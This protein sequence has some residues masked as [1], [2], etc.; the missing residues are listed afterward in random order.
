MADIY[1]QL[2]QS[3]AMLAGWDRP[4][5]VMADPPEPPPVCAHCGEVCRAGYGMAGRTYHLRCIPPALGEKGPEDFLRRCNHC[6][7][8]HPAH[9]YVER[10]GVGEACRWPYYKRLA[11]QHLET[12][13]REQ[14]ER[15]SRLF[16]DEGYADFLARHNDP[17]YVQREKRRA[18]EQ[19]RTQF[20]MR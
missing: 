10:D 13:R 17:A 11:M 9:S 20:Y 15:A 19:A 14:R 6:G 3:E 1:R 16:G 2:E 12:Q 4:D 7:Q 18:L 5:G 8:H